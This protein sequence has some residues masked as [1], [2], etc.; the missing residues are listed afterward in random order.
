MGCLDTVSLDEMVL[1]HAVV[2]SINTPLD[3][4]MDE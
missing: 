4:T 3:M 2:I 1:G